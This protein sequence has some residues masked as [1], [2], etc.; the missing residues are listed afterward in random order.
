MNGYSGG[1]IPNEDWLISP[2]LNLSAYESISFSFDHARNY[3]SNDGLFVLV[4]ADYDGSSDPSSNGTW[5]DLTSMFTFPEGGGSWDFIA[6][7]TAD[8][9][10]YSGTS[11][12]FA[13]KYTSTDAAASTWEIDNALIS[14]VAAVGVSEIKETTLQVFPNPA[15]N[16]VNINCDIEGQLR[17]INLAG[18]T[19]LELKTRKG[20]NQLNV[21]HLNQGLYMIQFTNHTGA[22]STQKLLI[23]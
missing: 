16:I 3:A 15:T 10:T 19:L 14:G 13:F 4:S 5:T 17:I 20:A 1:P 23:R 7:G 11:T 8:V 6:A 12:Y 9:S 22:V 2:E 21:Q 18:Q